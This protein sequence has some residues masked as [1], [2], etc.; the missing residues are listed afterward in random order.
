M[1]IYTIQTLTGTNEEADNS[2][3]ANIQTVLGTSENNRCESSFASTGTQFRNILEISQPLKHEPGKA[4]N[5]VTY[6]L[7]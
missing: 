4:Q 1:P 7:Y 5:A 3:G 6:I 2:A